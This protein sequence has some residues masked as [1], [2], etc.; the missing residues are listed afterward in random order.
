MNNG[1][2]LLFLQ[3]GILP[4]TY[5]T[6]NSPCGVCTLTGIKMSITVSNSLANDKYNNV[7]NTC[8]DE[9]IVKLATELKRLLI[10]TNIKTISHKYT[11]NMNCRAVYMSLYSS[12]FFI[13][14]YYKLS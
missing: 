12:Q 6:V 1:T 14:H 7:A 5:H 4:S 13:T 11:G 9:C 8:I 10:I 2:C 3:Y